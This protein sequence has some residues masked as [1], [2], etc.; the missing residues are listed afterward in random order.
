VGTIDGI[1]RQ[2]HNALALQPDRQ[3]EN[4]TAIFV[5]AIGSFS[6]SVHRRRSGHQWRLNGGSGSI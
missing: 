2:P 3:R 1:L 5:I 4:D 6:G